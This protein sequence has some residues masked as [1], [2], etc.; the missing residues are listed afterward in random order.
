VGLESLQA[1]RLCGRLCSAAT[2]GCSE[3]R[4][5]LPPPLTLP[6]QIPPH[7]LGVVERCNERRKHLNTFAN[8]IWK[9][10]VC[11]PLWRRK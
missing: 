11:S 8:F 6:A 9:Q 4:L 10:H 1:A 2:L 3:L 5:C 7:C